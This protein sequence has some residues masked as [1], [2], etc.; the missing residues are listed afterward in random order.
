MSCWLYEDGIGE[1]RAVLV[2]NGQIV[3]ALIVRE[4]RR[5]ALGAVVA[6]RIDTIAN[7]GAR[8]WVKL[9]G[10]A[11]AL[12]QPLPPGHSQ[13]A[14]VRGVVVRES[15]SE[16]GHA[17]RR[18]K[19]IRLRPISVETAPADAPRLIEQLKSGPIPVEQC[20]AHDTD[21][22][23]E[24]GWHELVEE[25]TS[26]IVAF[27]GGTLHISPTP[28]MTVIDIDGDL[29]PRALA[30][31]A[32]P[33]VAAAIRRL[34]LAGSIAIDFPTL[35][36]KTGRQAIVEAFDQATIGPHERTSVNGFG[37]MQVVRRRERPSLVELFAADRVHAELMDNL[38]RAERDRGTGPIT[39]VLDAEQMRIFASHPEWRDRL[40]RR[41]G[42]NVHL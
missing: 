32:A 36:D 16:F 20:H 28:A 24:A 21:R 1:E 3:E 27:A 31:A 4:D 13:G 37:L 8:A 11:L 18:L 19:P 9:D 14:E 42:R 33:A 25:A 22:L 38:R 10:G 40:A 29:P 41:T 30:M 2:E 12:L 23:G 17:S 35:A 15:L 39:L 6:G 7:D 26:G 5:L 34:G